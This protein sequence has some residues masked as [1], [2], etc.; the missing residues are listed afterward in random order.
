M[1][2]Q[3]ETADW[4]VHQERRYR[5]VI[6]PASP[7]LGGII[8]DYKTGHYGEDQYEDGYGICPVCGADT[9]TLI[10]ND[11]TEKIVGCDCCTREYSAIDC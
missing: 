8:D 5:M 1:P 6:N 4:E 7:S 11:F 10:Y 2:P 9:L 3:L